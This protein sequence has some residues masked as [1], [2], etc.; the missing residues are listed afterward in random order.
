M[1]LGVTGGGTGGH[2]YP[3]LVV[4]QLAQQRGAQLRY[5]GS[6]RGQEGK[7]CAARG[8]PFV[9]FSGGPLYT[10]KSIAGWK[11]LIG[12]MRGTTQAKANLRHDRP[13]VIFSTGGYSAAPVMKAAKSLGIPFVIHQVDSVPGRSNR[14]FADA[15]KSFTCVFEHTI[16]YMKERGVTATRTGQPI[17]PEL[18]AA[19]ER[20]Q[21]RKGNCVFVVGGSQGSEFLNKQIPRAAGIPSVKDIH[22]LHSTG[23]SH[24]D[25]TRK[26]IKEL[27]VGD[28]YQAYGYLETEQMVNAYLDSDLV[29]AR[30][31]GTIAE[32]ALFGL[33]S[34][35]VPLPTSADNHQYHNAEE[36]ARMN[37]AT[38]LTQEKAGTA[39]G[40]AT[41]IS[42]WLSDESA[43][44]IATENLKK[45]DQP[46]A[47]LRIVE[48]VEQAAK[49]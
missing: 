25:P 13:D 42:Y 6:L 47:T 43:R 5:L 32:I 40:I 28:R 33:P 8:I 19:A 15:A 30:S 3:A 11:S 18:R 29:I 9:G 45:W 46:E 38:L 10:L 21:T 36:F 22:F 24:I 34:I 35:L 23:P 17:R 14:M 12:L 37:A 39:E 1:K 49:K 20:T 48:L 27:A 2:I 4:A 44:Q 26:R 7:A 16:G 31:G 41:A